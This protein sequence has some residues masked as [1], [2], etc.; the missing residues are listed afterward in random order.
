L[1]HVKAPRIY[2]ISLRQASSATVSRGVEH[3]FWRSTVLASITKRKKRTV[4]SLK[5]SS[6]D[7]KVSKLT[8]NTLIKMQA[9]LGQGMK[10][11][12]GFRKNGHGFSSPSSVMHMMD[13]SSS[14]KSSMADRNAVRTHICVPLYFLWSRHSRFHV[15]EHCLHRFQPCPRP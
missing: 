14:A 11:Q 10:C 6:L 12:S 2:C 9:E 13:I 15:S 7:M 5:D 3:R 1:R 4:F 8:L